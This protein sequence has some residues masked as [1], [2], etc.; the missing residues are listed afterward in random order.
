M[1]PT[2]ADFTDR[3]WKIILKHRTPALVQRFLREIPYNRETE[4]SSCLSFRGVLAQ[5]RA[6][7]LEGAI[8]AAAILEQYDYPPILVSIESQDRLD[9]VL[10]LFREDG[11]FGS[12]A[13]SRDIG[14][15]G[16]KPVFRTVRDLVMSYFDAYIDKTGRITGYASASLYELGSYDWRFSMRNVWRV[17]RFLQEIPHR[18]IRSSDA[19][20]ERM[21]RRYLKFHEEHPGRSPD[22]FT[23]KQ[24][25]ML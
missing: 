17:E 13:R 2:R 14:L 4:A 1:K 8:V 12:V 15:H 9:H 21:R 3:E 5:N 22:Y 23:K 10:F 6:H 7:C 24:L 20:Y 19:R 16:R 11:R 18:Q 25:W